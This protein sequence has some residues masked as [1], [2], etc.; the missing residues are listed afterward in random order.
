MLDRASSFDNMICTSKGI[1]TH[2]TAHTAHS[3][4]YG[5][6]RHRHQHVVDAATQTRRLWV[7]ATTVP[8]FWQ[9]YQGS[10]Q[11]SESCSNLRMREPCQLKS[12]LQDKSNL[13]GSIVVLAFLNNIWQYSYSLAELPLPGGIVWV[14]N[15]CVR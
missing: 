7:N 8:I 13:Y 10:R 4:T 2:N 11:K 1:H 14:R 6:L 9:E 12:N 15:N 3:F 5:K